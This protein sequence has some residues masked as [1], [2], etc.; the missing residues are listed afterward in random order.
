MSNLWAG[1]R[2]AQVFERGNYLGVGVYDARV[3]RCLVKQTQRSGLGFIVE[4]EIL[5]STNM[6]H[7]P[8]TTATWFQSMK[9]QA[10]A[11]SAIKEFVVALHGYN[12]KQ[13]EAK[14]KNDLEP[15]IE[16]LI[17]NATGQNN[18]FA[19]KCIHL[20]T[21]MIKTREKGNDFTVHRWTPFEGVAP[22]TPVP[23]PS[24]INQ[25]PATPPGTGLPVR[26]FGTHDRA[27]LPASAA[28][29]PPQQFGAPQGA[30][31]GYAPQAPYAPHGPPP[32][33]APQGTPPG[34]ATQGAP[35]PYTPPPQ[36]P[37]PGYAPQMAPQTPP[38]ATPPPIVW[39][40]QG[41]VPSR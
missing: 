2:N 25:T 20:E 5:T 24:P 35:P 23:M 16:Q 39:N 18:S 38:Q 36:G 9:N 15:Y 21:F 10:T 29:A 32:G 11:F 28:F 33:Y 12:A 19:G 22:T 17:D 34:Y 26:P 41:W 40:G 31:P 13:D 8:G 37:P 14:I 6:S 27:P 1:L 3:I 7:Q 30:P 4:V